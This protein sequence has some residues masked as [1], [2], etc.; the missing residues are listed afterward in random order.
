MPA[1]VMHAYSDCDYCVDSRSARIAKT[2]TG[3]RAAST[4]II[5]QVGVKG[6]WIIRISGVLRPG[7]ILFP[8]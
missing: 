5:S 4:A 2:P 7:Y 8:G 1:F 3:V 6:I